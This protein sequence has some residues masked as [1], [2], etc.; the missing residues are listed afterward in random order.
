MAA[1]DRLPEFF[2]TAPFTLDEA[3]AAGSSYGQLC[4]RDVVTL[5]RGIKSLK[6][7]ADVPLALLTRPYT[8]VTGYAAA[9]HAT[10]FT[11]WQFPGFLPGATAPTIHISRQ[12]PHASMRREGVSGHRTRLFSDEVTS[13][14]GLWITTRSRTWLDCAHAMS[15]DELVIAADH[16]LRIPRP[17]YEG[18]DTP[19]ATV[20]AL[21]A[22]LD[23][24]HGMRG[25]VKARHALRLARVGC[26]SPPETRL[27]L[28]VVRAGL[29]EPR[30]NVA[31]QLAPGVE[32]TPDQ[33][34]PD[35]KVAVEYD[36]ATHADPAQV[37]K[38][39]T[40]EED[41]ARGG[42]KEVRIMKS[43]MAN[44]AEEAVSKIRNALYDRGWRPSGDQ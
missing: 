10:A 3:R 4:H 12:F 27:R 25:L 34:Y 17:Q 18:R 42:W 11:I 39:V 9:S 44:D 31:V 22:L 8:Q 20:P 43:H 40:R 24:H 15:L 23:S 35:Y 14:N 41:F 2:R 37:V 21:T 7:C 32:R 1:L 38:D 6:N 30:L 26:D 16:L 33:S 29:P 19:Y 13:L 5:S 36:G 28:A